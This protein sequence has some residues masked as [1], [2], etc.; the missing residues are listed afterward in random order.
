M[1]PRGGSGRGQGR[2]PRENAKRHNV[3]LEN[4]VWEYLSKTNASAEIERITRM[5]MEKKHLL[6][7]AEAIYSEVSGADNKTEHATT[8]GE[9]YDW[10]YEGDDDY[11]TADLA[12]LVR[13]WRAYNSA[14]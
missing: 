1:T 10:L 6:E 4:D 8:V 11:A 5:E 9:I 13:E 14:E 7:L 12:Y 3:I 2:K